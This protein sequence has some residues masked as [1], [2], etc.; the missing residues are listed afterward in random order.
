MTKNLIVITGASS[1][2]GAAMAKLFNAQGYPL[3]LVARRTEK[4]LALPLDFA[5]VQVASVD[6]RVQA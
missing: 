2:F 4:I 3:L 6:V 5:N 1:G